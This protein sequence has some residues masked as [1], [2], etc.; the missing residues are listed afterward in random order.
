MKKQSKERMKKLL[1]NYSPVQKIEWQIKEVKMYSTKE[2]KI[3]EEEIKFLE[4]EMNHVFNRDFANRCQI[5]KDVL[6]IK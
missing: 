4:K 6:K 5:I 2:I 3:I 1:K